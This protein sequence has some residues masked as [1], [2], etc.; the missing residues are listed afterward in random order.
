MENIIITV[1]I[2]VLIVVGLMYLYQK[3]ELESLRKDWRVKD[4][5]EWM[6]T[7]EGYDGS[8]A[9]RRNDE[10]KR[11]AENACSWACFQKIE[12]LGW[13]CVEETRDFPFDVHKENILRALRHLDRERGVDEST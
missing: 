4:W 3:S 8:F 6:K 7:L 12:G 11:W 2:I 13:I 5:C 10:A 9:I 1:L